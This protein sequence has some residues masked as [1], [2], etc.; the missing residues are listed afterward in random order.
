[1]GQLTDGVGQFLN[2]EMPVSRCHQTCGNAPVAVGQ[3]AV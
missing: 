2:E 3:A 1:M